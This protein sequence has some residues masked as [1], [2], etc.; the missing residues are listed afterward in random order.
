MRALHA[1]NNHHR[2]GRDSSKE[3][4]AG[5]HGFGWEWKQIAFASF[6]IVFLIGFLF[7]PVFSNSHSKQHSFGL[8]FITFTSC[9]LSYRLRENR[10][11]NE[12]RLKFQPRPMKIFFC[13]ERPWQSWKLYFQCTMINY[14]CERSGPSYPQE[15]TSIY[16]DRKAKNPGKLS[17][18][19]I[20]IWSSKFSR[21]LITSARGNFAARNDGHLMHFQINE[22]RT[23]VKAWRKLPK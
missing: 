9:M 2:D 19:F 3:N 1:G 13:Y 14:V 16:I 18:D 23:L 10:F 21:L 17:N 20:K 4:Y 15:S 22:L 7:W 8:P 6:F 5:F 12:S 11:T